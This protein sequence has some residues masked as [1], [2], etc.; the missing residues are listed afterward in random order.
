M[1]KRDTSRSWNK[2][3]NLTNPLL[4]KA[5]SEREARSA[6]DLRDE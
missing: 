6:R 4:I 5:R 1:E 3:A 2:L